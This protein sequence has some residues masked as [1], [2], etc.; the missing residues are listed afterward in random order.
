MP[1]IEKMDKFE[2]EL[3]DPKKHLPK[4][5][6]HKKAKFS[7]SIYN[8]KYDPQYVTHDD[9]PEVLNDYTNTQHT[10]KALGIPP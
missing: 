7:F 9:L 5:K 4:E 2:N 3:S 6:F 8:D 1:Q 10:V